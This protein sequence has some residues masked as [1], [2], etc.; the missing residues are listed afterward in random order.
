MGSTIGGPRFY[1][2]VPYYSGTN[3]TCGF[4]NIDEPGSSN[5]DIYVPNVGGPKVDVDIWVVDVVDGW[6]VDVHHASRK[7][8]FP[9]CDYQNIYIYIYFFIYRQLGGG[10]ATTTESDEKLQTPKESRRHMVDVHRPPVHH[11]LDGD[12]DHS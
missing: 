8:K 9:T 11:W 2:C 3:R 10:V 12:L 7:T 1:V 4:V 5:Q 6:T